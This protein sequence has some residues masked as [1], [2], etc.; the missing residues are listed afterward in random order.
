MKRFKL[1]AGILFI[2]PVTIFLLGFNFPEKKLDAPSKNNTIVLLKFKAQTGKSA[3]TISNL[4]NLFEKVREEPHFSSI[5][6]HVDPNDETNILLYEEWDDIDYY[7]GD[8]MKSAHLKNFMEN[9]GNFLTG[10]PEVTFW[11][12]V[13]EIK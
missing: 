3:E 9:S 1:L 2:L 8:H 12:V 7:Q 4:K 13:D 11:K 5:K 10:P 6:V